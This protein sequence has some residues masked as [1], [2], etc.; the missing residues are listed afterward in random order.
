MMKTP[1]LYLLRLHQ[2]VPDMVPVAASTWWRWVAEGKAPQ[3]VKIGPR[4]TGWRS[5]DIDE[6]IASRGV[7]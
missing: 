2:I 1:T 7:Q 6:F 5:S 4:T 3:P